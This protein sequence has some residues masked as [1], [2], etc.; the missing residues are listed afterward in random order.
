MLSYR[1]SAGRVE[2]VHCRLI[3]KIELIAS[4]Q[5]EVREALSLEPPNDRGTDQSTVA[6]YED[7]GLGIHVRVSQTSATLRMVASDALAGATV[8][9]TAGIG[10]RATTARWKIFTISDSATACRKEYSEE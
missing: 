10:A 4:S 1:N 8:C 5:E 6:S 3:P 2:L 9:T 7:T